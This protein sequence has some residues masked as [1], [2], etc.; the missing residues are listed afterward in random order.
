MQVTY[1]GQL[2]HLVASSFGWSAY[3]NT[4]RRRQRWRRPVFFAHSFWSFSSTLSSSS[5]SSSSPTLRA[6]VWT[7]YCCCALTLSLL[8]RRLSCC[9]AVAVFVEQCGS[10]FNLLYLLCFCF[11]I[12]FYKHTYIYPTVCTYAL[13]CP[14][15]FGFFCAPRFS[16]QIVE[17]KTERKSASQNQNQEREIVNDSKSNWR[18]L[19]HAIYSCAYTHTHPCIH[20]YIHTP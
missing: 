6:F 2:S 15:V 16:L 13:V 9:V 11:C 7:S 3:Q 14:Q 20:T 4:A 17:G 10:E 18:L 5:S 19:L 8:L 12:C 1:A